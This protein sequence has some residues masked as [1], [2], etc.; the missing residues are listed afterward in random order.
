MST[1]AIQPKLCGIK[2][3]PLVLDNL[4]EAVKHAIVVVGAR[5]GLAGLKLAGGVCG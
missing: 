3:I 5:G 4:L 1:R 2:S